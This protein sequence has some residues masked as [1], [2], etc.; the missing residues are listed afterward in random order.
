MSK[1]KSLLKYLKFYF[2]RYKEMIGLP[3]FCFE[4]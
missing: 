3:I 2:E 4:N 1:F